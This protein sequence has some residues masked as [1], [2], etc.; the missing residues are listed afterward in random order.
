MARDGQQSFLL[1]R[2]AHLISYFSIRSSC[3]A[4][5]DSVGQII[6]IPP[7]SINVERPHCKGN[8][9]GARKAWET[10]VDER[11]RPSPK[12]DIRIIW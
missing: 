5:L 2:K 9:Q 1:D 6:M 3:R 10:C 11:C 7:L 8:R 4:V 12:V